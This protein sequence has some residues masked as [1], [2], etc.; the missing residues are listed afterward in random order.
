MPKAMEK[1]KAELRAGL[2]IIISLFL[3]IFSVLWL[4]YF[5][6]KP[7]MT[8]IA[9]FKDPGPIAKGLQVYYQGVNIGKV[10]NIDF[11]KDYKY[12]LV[13]ISI[14]RKNLRLPANVVA[15]ID[16]QGITG[17]KFV[18]IKYPDNPVS[19]LL[20]N[21][22]SITGE[23]PFGLSDLQEMLGKQIKNGRL[24]K[25][26][27][28]FEKSFE[29]QV[30]LSQDMQKL[31]DTATTLIEENKAKVSAL[32]NEGAK[33]A[34]NL[35][36]IFL[37]INEIIGDPET[38][39]SIKS[40]V[41][42]AGYAATGLCGILQSDGFSNSMSDISRITK[43]IREITED[44]EIKEGLS[45]TFKLIEETRQ[46]LSGVRSSGIMNKI[47]G[48]CAPSAGANIIDLAVETMQ[49]TN[50]AAKSVNCL[51]QG[52]CD[53]LDKRFVLLRLMFGK[54]GSSLEICKN[55]GKLSKE[56]IDYLSKQGVI[57]PSCSCKNK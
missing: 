7:Y 9:K 37:N 18:N 29:I 5:A 36:K 30:Q 41:K 21:G 11:S 49:N 27:E 14:Y 46:T 42:S 6:I 52:M 12:T 33:T 26:V 47:S 32:I 50:Q 25:M 54:P 3:L 22:C 55:I 44:E 53:I 45:N 39:R 40:T 34:T 1:R 2:F 38:K 43:N 19:E 20:C 15:R 13:H 24:Q 48:A 4:R 10:Y 28:N 56:Q 31:A 51:S 16:S 8:V 35:N 17:Q 23:I 57:D